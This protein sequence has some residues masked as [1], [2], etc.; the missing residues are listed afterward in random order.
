MGVLGVL[1]LDRFGGGVR[2]R[3]STS[4][5]GTGND[6]IL[7]L[8]GVPR[9]SRLSGGNLIGCRFFLLVC[10]AAG[11]LST[12][13]EPDPTVRPRLCLIVPLL[14]RGVSVFVGS[15]PRLSICRSSVS[16]RPGL[17]VGSE[18]DGWADDSLRAEV[19]NEKML[20]SGSFGD[21][22][23]F[24]MAGTGGTSSSTSPAEL[25]TLRG[26]GVGSRDPERAGLPRV[27]SV[28]VPSLNEFRLEFDDNDIPD[29]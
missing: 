18:G 25:W 1:L 24:G 21:S 26:L 29:A 11:V 2:L 12:S 7:L 5:D 14:L 6:D 10:G 22:Y 9:G 19:E 4:A 28:P 16:S 3:P 27:W 17:F 8:K 20:C 23:A 15:M 13:T